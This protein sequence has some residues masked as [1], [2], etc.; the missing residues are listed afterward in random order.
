MK[1]MPRS[2]VERVQR[3]VRLPSDADTLLVKGAKARKESIAKALEHAVRHTYGN[4]VTPEKAKARVR[5]PRVGDD[6]ARSPAP[7]PVK[8]PTKK[9]K[10]T[11]K[12]FTPEPTIVEVETPTEGTPFEKTVEVAK[13]AVKKT[14]RK[15]DQ[16]EPRFKSK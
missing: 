14:D 8:K 9:R 16:V 1:H 2:S 4:G 10:G 5:G 15:H 6:A 7:K 11:G 13:S 12:R 3:N